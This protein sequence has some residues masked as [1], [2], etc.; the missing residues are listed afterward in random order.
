ML[1]KMASAVSV[2]LFVVGAA[3]A[4]A[5]PS[6]DSG[7]QHSQPAPINA[8]VASVFAQY[9]GGGPEMIE[10]L[11]SLLAQ[12]PKLANDIVE[13]ARN[14]PPEQK[15]SAGRALGEAQ[16]MYADAGNPGAAEFI[17]RAA[18]HADSQVY[19]AYESA[20]GDTV[21]DESSSG[22]GHDLG[23][24]GVGNFG[25]GGGGVGGIGSISPH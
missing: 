11:K 1:K 8:Q 2:A 12:D 7:A 24:G 22:H 3:P 15:D 10:A 9:P 6:H 14:A 23:Y 5:R 16:Q 25:G 18:H 19:A 17:R 21:A 13:A 20:L 4:I